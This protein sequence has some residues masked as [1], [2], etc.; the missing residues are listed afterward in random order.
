[1]GTSIGKTQPLVRYVMAISIVLTAGDSLSGDSGNRGLRVA[2]QC[3]D[4]NCYKNGHKLYGRI[5]LVTS[6]P[7]IKAKVVTSFPDLKVKI[8]ESAPTKCGEWKIVNEFPDL[9][10]QLVDSSPDIRIQFVQS[11]PG[12][13]A[14]K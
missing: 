1:M 8:V 3:Q 4:E 2:N 12:L 7:D 14:S 9:K 5:K 6:F 10:V 11:F 13:G